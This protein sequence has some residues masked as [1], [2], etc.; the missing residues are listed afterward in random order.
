MPPAFL[1]VTYV[2]LS[3]RDLPRSAAWYREVLGLEIKR[4]NI[5][6]SAWPA[7]W[8]EV[9]LRHP[10]SGLLIGLLQHPSNLG[11]A[12]SE[13]QTGLDHL[14][15]EVASQDELDVWRHRLDSLGVSHSGAHNH[16]VT[17]RDPDNIQLELFVRKPP[18]GSSCQVRTSRRTQCALRFESITSQAVGRGKGY[19]GAQALWRSEAT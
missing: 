15:L 6:G 7:D 8:D 11:D 19:R 5:G 12:F 2:G 16:I 1:G 13:F 9:L 14:E 10:D 4:E 17:L 3:V 18:A